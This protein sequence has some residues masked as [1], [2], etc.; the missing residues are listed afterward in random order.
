VNS[1]WLLSTWRWPPVLV[2]IG[3]KTLPL[4]GTLAFAVSATDPNFD[5]VQFAVT[6]LPDRA[7]F[8][9][10]TW[11]FIFTRSRSRSGA[12]H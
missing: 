7:S 5:P 9:S 2:Q 6:P 10:Q 4:G 8:N 11:Q 1:G 12:L 3:N